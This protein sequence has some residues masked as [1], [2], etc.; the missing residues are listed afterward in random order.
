MIR[1][2]LTICLFVSVATVVMA[3]QVLAQSLEA[4]PIYGADVPE[5][6]VVEHLG[7][8]ISFDTEFVDSDGESVRVGD[9]FGQDRPVILSFAYH[10]CPML[11]SLV[12]DGVSQAII[13]TDL[14]P[15]SDFEVV[16]VSFNHSEGPERAAAA[17]AM[18]VQRTESGKPD[19]ALNW[20]FLT[21]SEEAIRSLSDE[22]GFGFEWDEAT[23]QF[24]HNAI[25]VFISPEGTI[26]RYLYGI[27]HNPRDFRL[28]TV[29][30]GQGTVGSTL[31]RFLLTCF[32]Y[33][34]SSRSY[35]FYIANIMKLGG[36]LLLL[37]MAAFF[38]PMWLRERKRG[39]TS[40]QFNLDRGLT[41]D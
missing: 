29:E 16:N 37:I 21:G 22:I 33:D 31:D 2:A 6:T 36:A 9:Y 23:Q 3:G 11:C 34:T 20:H 38:V 1:R 19:I 26:T 40:A 13:E 8:Q 5:V 18:Y 17:K 41:T 7:E 24:A 15:G 10:D 12:L 25:L 28:A 35:S 14:T 39:S 30:A 27:Q 4:Q 32:Q